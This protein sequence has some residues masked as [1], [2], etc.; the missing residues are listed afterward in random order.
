MRHRKAEVLVLKDLPEN[1]IRC[2]LVDLDGGHVVLRMGPTGDL[3]S[4]FSLCL[5][6]RRKEVENLRRERVVLSGHGPELG[7]FHIGHVC[8][9]HLV[10]IRKLVALYVDHVEVRIALEDQGLCRSP[11]DHFPR[12]QNRFLLIG[13]LIPSV[14]L[15]LQQGRPSS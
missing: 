13:V 10:E 2:R 7:G 15:V 3:Y 8:Y 12:V 1:W 4:P 14:G 5:F 11:L 6:R 9:V